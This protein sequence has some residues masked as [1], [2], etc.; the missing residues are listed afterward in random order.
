ME[1]EYNCDES[2]KTRFNQERIADLTEDFLN[3]GLNFD[4]KSEL[5]DRQYVVSYIEGNSEYADIPLSVET[6]VFS[7]IF[8]QLPSQIINDYGKYDQKSVFATVI[9]TSLE[10]SLPVGILRIV[11]FDPQI[12]FKDVNDLVEDSPNNPWLDELKTG[13]FDT[14]ESYSEEQAWQRLSER[15]KVNLELEK[16]LDIATHA[17]ADH[18]RGAHGDINGVSM[19]FYHACLRYALAHKKDNLLA[20]FDIPPLENL[21]QFGNPF[22]TYSGLSARPYGGPY[23]T[24]PAFCIIE[25]GMARIRDQSK[26]IGRVFIDGLTLNDNAILPNEYLPEIYSN[27]SVNLEKI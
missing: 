4:V 17:S 7:K 13:Y 24:L 3:K 15:E 22:D 14:D 23:E 10:R 12:G 16:S 8:K 11:G 1:K 6:D 2:L 26:D 5:K 9:D 21:Q 18:Y 20:I 19:L 25:R 27:E